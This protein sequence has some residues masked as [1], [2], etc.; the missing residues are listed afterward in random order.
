MD[1]AIHEE[2]NICFVV[3]NVVEETNREG[4]GD[5]IGQGRGCV[6]CRDRGRPL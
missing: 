3:V 4:E 6:S 1:W 5:A 2:I